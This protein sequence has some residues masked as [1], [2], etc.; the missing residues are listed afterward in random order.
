VFS[1]GVL[2]VS[3]QCVGGVSVGF[4]SGIRPRGAEE[5]ERLDCIRRAGKGAVDLI[6]E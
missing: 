2:I 3:G 6:A 4:S 1:K 5:G